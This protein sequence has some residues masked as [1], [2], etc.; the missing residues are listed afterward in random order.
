MSVLLALAATVSATKLEDHAC[1]RRQEDGHF[2]D[3][4]DKGLT[5]TIPPSLGDHTRLVTVALARN[6]LGGT[7]PFALGK[8]TR[9]NAL[10]LGSDAGQPDKQITGTIPPSLGM[11]TRLSALGLLGSKTHGSE[12]TGT[13][14][15]TLGKLTALTY[16][17]LLSL[18]LSGTI[19]SALGDLTLLTYL[20]RRGAIA[21]ALSPYIYVRILICS[22]VFCAISGSAR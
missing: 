8:L 5:G 22:R 18:Q 1:W 2:L 15:S 14:P 10:L 19:P 21:I 9:L 20:A 16:L 17:H 13:L 12:L 4:F 7:I 3:C 11:L 6:E